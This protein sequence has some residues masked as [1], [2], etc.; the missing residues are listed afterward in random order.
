[1]TGHTETI[2]ILG[3]TGSVGRQAVDL[4]LSHPGRFSVDTLAAHSNVKIFIDQAQKLRPKMVA[5]FDQSAHAELQSLLAP[6]GIE[7]TAGVNAVCDAARRPVDI[8]VAAIAGFAALAPTMAALSSSKR[9]AFV[10]KECLVCAGDLFLAEAAKHGCR[11]IPTDSEHS[12]I[13]QLLARAENPHAVK[14]VT[15]TASGGPFLHFTADQMRHITPD[16]ATAHPVWRMGKKISVDSA[17]MFNKGLEI[18]E[19]HHL[20]QLP[21]EKIDVVI[22]PEGIVHAFVTYADGAV[23]THM[24]VPDM[25]IPLSYAMFWPHRAH[26]PSTHL[27]I[28]KM[29][30]LQ[31]MLPDMEK[32]PSLQLA[33]NCLQSGGMASVAL[34]AANE[35]A[36][37]AFLAKQIGF[38]DIFALVADVLRSAAGLAAWAQKPQ[39]V[40]EIAAFDAEIRMRAQS[41]RR[42]NLVKAA[43]G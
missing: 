5:V 10:S 9:L 11:I 31:F 28:T 21:S 24:G 35:V 25:K 7:V 32:F 12:A 1:M 8:T 38:M 43:S 20:F 15:L 27:D 40:A 3:S 2:S 6:L 16:Q 17:T 33:R 14:N 13:F 30:K 34:N 37:S 36:V 4:I 23:L 19:T 42:H 18:I 22:H 26:L 41:W 39:S 29:P